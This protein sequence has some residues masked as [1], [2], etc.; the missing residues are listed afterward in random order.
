MMAGHVGD[1]R[2]LLTV[3]DNL[4]LTLILI[5]SVASIL[6]DYILDNANHYVRDLIYIADRRA[7]Q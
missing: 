5:F 6:L 4:K 7:L 3:I 1:G 2:R